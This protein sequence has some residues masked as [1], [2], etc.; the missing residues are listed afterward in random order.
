MYEHKKNQLKSKHKL[1][2]MER[3]TNVVP[4][5]KTTISKKSGEPTI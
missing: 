2:C 3:K 4:D 5:E 1:F